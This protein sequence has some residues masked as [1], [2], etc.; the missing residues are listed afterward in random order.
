MTKGLISK[1]ELKPF[2]Q[3][4][5]FKALMV[6]AW[7]WLSIIF[8][9]ALAAIYSNWLVYGL[10]I[11]LLAGRQQA[12][13]ALM[14]EAGHNTFFKTKKYNE[15]VTNW[16][17]APFLLMDGRTYSRW[18]LEHHKNA[19]TKDD[20]D[21]ANYQNYPVTKMSLV[22]KFGRDVLGVTG[23]KLI[24]YLALTGK[25]S[26]TR[27]KRAPFTITKGLVFNG[28][29]FLILWSVGQA[30]LFSLWVIAYFT[31]YMFIIR[32]RQIA[33]HAGVK[34][35]FNLDP[36]YNTRSVPQGLL[37]FLFFSP[38]QGLSYHCEH[39]AFM[40]VPSYNLKAV[41]K[42]LKSKGYY[43]DVRLAKGYLDIFPEIIK[44]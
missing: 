11:C 31:V 33:E 28:A 18:H 38:T 2:M 17:S 35:L 39:H 44:S 25:D 5:D 14:H 41:H 9:F 34:D 26:L 8:C 10:V 30:H 24:A 43:D 42:L 13:A 20:P 6:T 12:L 40:A 1:E 21:L 23:V 36:K 37:G 16:L 7:I 15:F 32:Y 3:R 29:L 19:G 22:R 27:Q 4:S